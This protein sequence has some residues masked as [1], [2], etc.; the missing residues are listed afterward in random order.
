M[1][2]SEVAAAKTGSLAKGLIAGCIG[3]LAGTLAKTFAERMFPPQPPAGQLP[4]QI[5]SEC[6]RQPP[7]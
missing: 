4:R 3:G 5:P 6:H 7:W 1:K 2:K